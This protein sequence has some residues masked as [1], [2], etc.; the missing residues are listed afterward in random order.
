VI[1]GL[2][3]VEA[4]TTAAGG[5]RVRHPD[6][7]V[8]IAPSPLAAPANYFELT[9]PAVAN[10]PYHLWLRGRAD[11]N[12]WRNDS[13]WVQFSNVDAYPIGTVKAATVTLE[14]CTGCGESGWGWQDN[15]FGLNV[16]GPDIVFTTSGVQTIRIQTREDGFSIDQIVLSPSRFLDAAPG[17]VKDDAT[18]HPATQP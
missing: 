8:P 2:W 1:A 17:S 13:A 6:A 7:G 3:R 9:F 15:G 4:S 16:L 11:A 10:V 14:D 5:Y 12:G 18:I